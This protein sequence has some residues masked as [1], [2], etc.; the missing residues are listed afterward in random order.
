MDEVLE[1][2]TL[3]I[4]YEGIGA[5]LSVGGY[6]AV[7]VKDEAVYLARRYMF[8]GK[9]CAIDRFHSIVEHEACTNSDA[10]RRPLQYTIDRIFHIVTIKR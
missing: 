4:I 1:W 8:P 2:T 6:G 5:N 7:C 3:G 10:G 9:E